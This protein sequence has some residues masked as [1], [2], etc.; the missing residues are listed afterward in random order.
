MKS[1]LWF[2]RGIVK[3]QETERWQDSFDLLPGST[4]GDLWFI[5]MVK[6]DTHPPIYA[7]VLVFISSDRRKFVVEWRLN[8]AK[9]KSNEERVKEKGVNVGNKENKNDER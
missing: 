5:K 9:T 7:P 3:S 6:R 4:K 2:K 1:Y 8:G